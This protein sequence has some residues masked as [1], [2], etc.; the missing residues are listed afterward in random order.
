MRDMSMF[1]YAATKS[2]T[3]IYTLHIQTGAPLTVPDVSPGFHIHPG[4]PLT[5]PDPL[6]QLCSKVSLYGLK[7]PRPERRPLPQIQIQIQ[8]RRG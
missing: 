4:T 7:A 2:N 3:T 1:L 5:V 6:S 8:Q